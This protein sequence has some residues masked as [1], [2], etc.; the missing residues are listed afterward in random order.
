VAGDAALEAGQR[1]HDHI[2]L[3][4]PEAG[5]T[6]GLQDA[7]DP[8]ART[9]DADR[10][11]GRVARAEELAAHGLPDHADIDATANLRF[12]EASAKRDVPVAR[13]EIV[14]VGAGHLGR[15]V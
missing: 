11:A 10:L 15:D 2:V 7:D 1:H 5:R 6:L 4:L 3:I 14:D 8:A 9:V 13:D 12:G